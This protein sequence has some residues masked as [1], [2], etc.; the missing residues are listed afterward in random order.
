MCGTLA[1]YIAVDLESGYVDDLSVAP[2]FSGCGLGTRLLLAGAEAV[3]DNHNKKSAGKG[4]PQLCLHVRA[5]NR[6]AIC[7]YTMLGFELGELEFPSW[8]DWHGGYELQ[9]NCADVVTRA[10]QRLC[11]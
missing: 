2:D 4:S 10:R 5:A 9:A 3:T 1:G 8:F 11:S 7:L 6:P